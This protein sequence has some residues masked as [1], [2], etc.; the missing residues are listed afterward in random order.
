[1]FCVNI[2]YT[3][4]KILFWYRL[5]CKYQRIINSVNNMVNSNKTMYGQKE[6]IYVLKGMKI[7]AKL[8][9]IMAVL[10][11]LLQGG[12]TSVV[13]TQVK[14][15]S[16][17]QARATAEY[18]SRCFAKELKS[19]FN[20]VQGSLNSL[21]SYL[22]FGRT[23]K[24]LER[25]DVT[26]AI[27]RTLKEND[28]IYGIY[29][30]YLPQ[31]FDGKDQSN[32]GATYS[33][34]TGRFSPYIVKEGTTAKAQA[35]HEFKEEMNAA[36]FKL[37]EERGM[38]TL[39]PPYVQKV[40][41]EEK[42]LLTLAVPLYD[43]D[44][45]FIG[46]MGADIDLQTFQK[47][48]EEIKPLGGYTAI[49]SD[50][51]FIVS[52]GADKALVGQNFLEKDPD[53]KELFKEVVAGSEKSIY[54][55]AL[56]GGKALRLFMPLKMPGTDKNW[57]LCTVIK[58][59]DLLS[60]YN[61]LKGKLLVANLVILVIMILVLISVVTWTVKP[62]S[63]AAKYLGNFRK[64]NFHV[65]MPKVMKAAG[66]EVGL[67]VDAIEEMKSSL[68]GIVGEL[69][70]NS[71]QTENAVETVEKHM[72]SLNSHIQEI[73][74]STEELSA[75]MEETTASTDIT[76]AKAQELR[77]SIESLAERANGSKLTAVEIKDKAEIVKTNAE[78][79]LVTTEKLYAESHESLAGAI[80]NAK[81]VEQITV[82][83]DAILNIATQ[84]NLL[85]LNA[86]IEAARAGD[87]GKGF[88][89]VATEIRKLAEE[90][91]TTV[92]EIQKVTV[93]ILSS[94]NGLTKHSSDIMDFIDTKVMEDYKTLVD[95]SEEFAEN[96]NY[97]LELSNEISE[98]TEA[99][100]AN[101]ESI[102]ESMAT[103]DKASEEGTSA[104]LTIAENG[105]NVAAAA[106]EVLDQTMKA[107]RSTE[108]LNRV[109][110]KIKL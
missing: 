74:A 75:G 24:V 47:K 89:V 110:D 30:S 33:D 16:L 81:S 103:I 41:G 100:A 55:K 98:T 2:L 60:N 63:A 35:S 107:R 15:N 11:V 17:S 36:Y 9:L 7:A 92:E 58:E 93:D 6:G 68:K 91:K 28:F 71:N 25:K 31:A 61:T 45:S 18:S 46:V 44:K 32:V 53:T 4:N 57:A 70:E 29:I 54:N 21:S 5:L 76:L 22:S 79:S 52:H 66:G 73:S 104:S 40:N 94:V 37:A 38:I 77:A 88:S 69:K 64:L 12:L 43:E 34:S 65:E 1:M 49:L 80:E 8:S 39:V 108:D 48:I 96:A 19:D 10:M 99:L 14:D 102:T 67:L 87:A 83:S 106:G 105:S 84:T 27:T 50:N 86:A 97:Y 62:I 59:G 101:V 42:V 90:S 109:M 78:N 72:H 20:G 51:G 26:D 82:L 85:A 95:T 23:K 56:V 13:L 3:I